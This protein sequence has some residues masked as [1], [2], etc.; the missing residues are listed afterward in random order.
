MMGYEDACPNPLP[1]LVSYAMGPSPM[2]VPFWP[3]AA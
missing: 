2:D 1:V 3:G